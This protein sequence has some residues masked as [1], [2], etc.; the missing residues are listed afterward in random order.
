MTSNRLLPI[1][2]LL[3]VLWAPVN[4]MVDWAKRGGLSSVAVGCIR[5]T[6]LAI[7]VQLLLTIPKFREIT[8]AK[9]RPRA[10]WVRSF[11]NGLI[12]FGPAHLLYY[13]SMGLTDEVTANV[14]LSTSPIWTTFFAFFLLHERV[15]VQR[16]VAIGLSMVGA[17]VTAI[18]F[19]IPSIQGNSLGNLMFFSG[20]VIECINGVYATQIARRNSGVTVLS[21][22]MWGGATTFI[23]AALIF[24]QQL[25]FTLATDPMGYLPI[26]YLVL[27]SGIITFTVWYRIV[28]SAPLT[29]LVVGIALQPPIAGVINWFAKSQIPTTNTIIGSIII[30]VAL[31]LGFVGKIE[32]VERIEA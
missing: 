3:N 31:V 25:P 5:W 7:L 24:R 2:L 13:A 17:Y 23:L 27:I 28:E 11:V 8:G 30:L 26:A 6:I 9:T 19:Q 21:A 32:K 14:L 12:L 18:G 20:V 15:P 1:V 29:L 10:D 16:K 4:F 22:Q